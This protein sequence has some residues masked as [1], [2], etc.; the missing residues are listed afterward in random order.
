MSFRRRM[1]MAVNNGSVYPS[2]AIMTIETNPEVLAICYAKGWCA[3]SDYMTAREAAAV[4]D[5]GTTFQSKTSIK[6]F[7]ELQFFSLT[8]IPNFA[9]KQCYNL[10]SITL[11]KTVNYLGLQGFYNCSKLSSITIDR[12]TA[13]TINANTCFG[14]KNGGTLYV[15]IGSTGYNVWMGTGNYYLGKYNWTKVEV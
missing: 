2:D 12:A 15:P 10:E 7:D 9:F 5:I 13:P 14:V 8:I 1:M 6:H 11:P 3:N 4:T